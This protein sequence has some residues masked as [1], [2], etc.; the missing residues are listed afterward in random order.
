VLRARN[1]LERRGR[2][3]QYLL[4]LVEHIHDPEPL[5]EIRH[6]RNVV[7]ALCD[8]DDLRDLLQPRL[9]R[10]RPDVIED[11]ELAHGATPVNVDRYSKGW[12]SR[13]NRKT[14]K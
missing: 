3:R 8:I 10:F 11:V 7:A 12:V 13:D 6:H 14:R 4:V 9:K 1:D 5:V 2:K